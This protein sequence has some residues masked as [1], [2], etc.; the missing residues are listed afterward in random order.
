M[1][2][3]TTEDKPT[4]PADIV[5]LKHPN[6]TWRKTWNQWICLG[7]II[8]KVRPVNTEW[9]ILLIKWSAAGCDWPMD[10]F[11]HISGVLWTSFLQWHF[12]APLHQCR[13][14]KWRKHVAKLLDLSPREA[15]GEEKPTM[16]VQTG[17]TGR[18]YGL[19][20]S[21]VFW[22]LWYSYIAVVGCFFC[23]NRTKKK[24]FFWF[25]KS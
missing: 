16:I 4:V 1:Q 2:N 8:L 17:W 9:N 19:L 10:W 18:F 20:W 11:M 12:S 7:R 24:K 13:R 21:S 15:G 6:P 14:S 23:Y 5:I 25:L 3:I 22:G